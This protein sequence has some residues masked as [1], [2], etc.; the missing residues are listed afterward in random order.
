MNAH[1]TDERI[2]MLRQLWRD[3]RSCS[4]IAAILG[5]GATRN[6]VIGKVHRLGLPDRKGADTAAAIAGRLAAAETKKAKS[7]RQRAHNPGFVRP[8][9]W[10]DLYSHLRSDAAYRAALA[11]LTR[12]A[13]VGSEASD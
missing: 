12:P 5:G 8:E 4:E 1:W 10:P 11:A 7:A 6:S 13:K 3:G 9:P 2:E